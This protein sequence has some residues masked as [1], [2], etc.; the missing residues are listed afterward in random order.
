[1]APTE[2]RLVGAKDT[3]PIGTSNPRQGKPAKLDQIPQSTAPAPDDGVATGPVVVDK[4]K[5]G[6]SISHDSNVEG[7][8]VAMNKA[9]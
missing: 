4:R 9:G 1:M 8:Q 2:R 5:P 6:R 3:H 7:G